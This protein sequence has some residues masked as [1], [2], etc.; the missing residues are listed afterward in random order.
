MPMPFRLTVSILSFAA[1]LALAAAPAGAQS[2]WDQPAANAPGA[3]G[4]FAPPSQ[5]QQQVC[6]SE[7]APLRDD[8]E[9]K[10]TA[11]RTASKRH[12][13][14]DEA[15]N[16]FKILAASQEKL[17]KYVQVNATRCSIPPQVAGQLKTA[18]TQVT[19]I[20]TKVCEAAARG[21]VPTGPSL[22]DALGTS[23]LADPSNIKTGRGTFDT[24]TGTPLGTTR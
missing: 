7:F 19:T 16:L 4:G 1:L 18:L 17:L 15:C 10:A 24:L 22:S 11:V 21:P 8:A 2:V 23:R 14:P 3:P 9:K 12:P 5:Q 13:R 20:R 6:M